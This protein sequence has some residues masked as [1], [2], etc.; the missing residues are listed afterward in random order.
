MTALPPRHVSSLL[1]IDRQRLLGSCAVTV[2]AIRLFDQLP[3][4]PV[5][6]LAGAMTVL[7]TTKPT[8]AKAIE[9]L[10]TAKILRETTGRRRDR[11]YAYT[12]YLELL[13]GES[14]SI[15]P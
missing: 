2:P 1:N 11:I 12:A 5:V 6:T 10:R 4:H 8:T 15:A 9:S 13:T 7:K 14:R 3:D